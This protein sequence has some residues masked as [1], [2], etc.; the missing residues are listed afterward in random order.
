MVSSRALVARSP[1]GDHRW[2]RGDARRRPTTS[3]ASK[4]IVLSGPNS[5][6]RATAAFTG[7]G[8]T[9]ECRPGRTG[10]LASSRH[11]KPRA[12]SRD[13][14]PGI[15]LHRPGEVAH[16]G[17][18]DRCSSQETLSGREARERT[19]Q[20]LPH[21]AGCGS[22]V[23]P[24]SRTASR[25]ATPAGP[26]ASRLRRVRPVSPEQSSLSSPLRGRRRPPRH[27][28]EGACIGSLRAAPSGRQQV[29]ARAAPALG[30]A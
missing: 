26:P 30:H 11:D 3:S 8:T 6:R 28:A 21:L 29:G 13:S 27:G 25:T 4:T 1:S 15:Q 23:A 19:G 24:A 14:K 20:L 18:L 2:D 22:T 9:L 10:S 16:G 7:A 5:L 12:L 17:S